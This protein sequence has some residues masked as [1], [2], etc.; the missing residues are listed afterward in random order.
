MSSFPLVIGLEGTER[1][2]LPVTNRVRTWTWDSPILVKHSFQCSVIP[3]TTWFVD[4]T[5]FPSWQFVPRC[6][7]GKYS[8][9]WWE[10]NKMVTS[11]WSSCAIS[12]WY[13]TPT[14]RDRVISGEILAV[15]T[16]IN[17]PYKWFLICNYVIKLSHKQAG[18]WRWMMGCS[19]ILNKRWSHHHLFWSWELCIN[20]SL[21]I[22]S[23]L[24]A[25]PY[26]PMPL[27]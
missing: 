23:K 16:P 20:G 25:K 22:N 4:H 6:S 27:T 24:N 21:E 12:T 8:F 5:V 17:F 14:S 10:I 15:N 9:L 18:P 19:D 26:E 3:P 7:V 11:S 1:F 2:C 13:F